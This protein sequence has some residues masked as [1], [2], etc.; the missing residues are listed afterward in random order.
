[1]KRPA[2]YNSKH[3]QFAD[4]LDAWRSS[5]VLSHPLHGDLALRVVA[6]PED[7]RWQPCPIPNTEVRLL[8]YR[9]GSNPRF[10]ALL[11]QTQNIDACD[12]GYWRRLEVMVLGGA[13]DLTDSVA[14]GG[15]YVRLPA[16]EHPLQFIPGKPF[17]PL[18]GHLYVAFSGGNY[19]KD[20]DERRSIAT[21]VPDAWLP[22]PTNGIE[23]LPLHVHGS[24]NV[25]LLRWTQ[26]A[27]FQPQ[28]DPKGEEILVLSGAL[29]DERGRYEAGTWVRNPE[30][31]WQHWS[32]AK[33][34]VV[35]YKTGH[36]N[37]DDNT[38]TATD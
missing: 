8:E 17:W 16:L 34:T 13:L 7:A 23:V 29:A 4:Q 6:L 30:V 3:E 38:D 27:S 10:T 28:L 25:M 18:Q 9:G 1:M 15:N 31:S 20:D 14:D 21:D 12:L 32:G 24:A 22:G 19:L 35:F 37:A 11:R 36:F 26:T 33:G 2:D 5:A